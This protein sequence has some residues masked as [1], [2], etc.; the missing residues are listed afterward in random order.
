MAGLTLSSLS[1]ANET[2]PSSPPDNSLMNVHNQCIVRLND[3]TEG[4]QVPGIAKSLA[5][6]ANANLTHVYSHSIKGFTVDIPC[7][8]AAVIFGKDAEIISLTPDGVVSINK[9]KPSGGGGSTSN[10]EQTSYGTTRVGGPIDGNAYT[11][12]IIDTGIDLDHPDLNVDATRGFTA[13]SDG[14]G[15]DD[16]NGH[17][18]H[19]SGIIAAIDN[20][21]GSV[22]VAQGATVIPVRVLNRRGSGTISGV[23]AGVDHVAANASI[24]DCVNMSLGGSVFQ[25]LDD[26]VIAASNN[27]GA[28]FAV[29]AG[30]SGDNANNYSPARANGSNVWTI[31]AIDSN[32]AMPSWSN[33]GN[34]PVDFAAPGVTIFSL[35][36]DGK[37]N[38]ISGT[39]MATPHAC[40]VLMLTGGLPNS[41]GTA[42]NDPDGDP[43]L[44]IHN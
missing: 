2:A 28:F 11:A 22:G 27:S 41:S 40:A 8:A 36:K 4:A 6:R 29:A 18:T 25:P 37:T 12:W 16:K 44:I 42:S 34:P 7:S 32:D 24:G 15:M 26:A 35:W 17:G 14:G 1:N 20:E 43:D 9:G 3:Q 19:V 5:A 10:P 13:I 38:T 39:S 23:I 21:I 30:N 31:S 33:Y